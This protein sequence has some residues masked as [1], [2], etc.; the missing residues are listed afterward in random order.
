MAGCCCSPLGPGSAAAV[1]SFFFKLVTF[2]SAEF[3]NNTNWQHIPNV[4]NQFGGVLGSGFTLN[5]STGVVTYTG[6]GG[7]F[8]IAA[9]AYLSRN[10]PAD[11]HCAISL[12]GG[13]AI[14]TATAYDH[15]VNQVSD[16]STGGRNYVG[17][18]RMLTLATNDTIEIVYRQANATSAAGMKVETLA[19][20]FTPVT[21]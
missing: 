2:P 10:A 9:H 5:A 4:A 8:L 6:P 19:V 21:L 12:N 13:V 20:A 14:G 3:P 18:C 1:A 7:T 15:E 16:S 17:P 11:T